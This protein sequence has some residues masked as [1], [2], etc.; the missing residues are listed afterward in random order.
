MTWATCVLAANPGPMTL[1]GT[2][3]WVLR[4]PGGRRSV[5]VDPGPLD[6]QHLA[7][8]LAV[9]DPVAL[10]LITHRHADHTDAV[11]RFAELTGAPVRAADPDH[12]I[13]DDGLSDGD[14]VEVDGLRVETLATPGHTADSVSFLLPDAGAVLTGDTVLGRGTSVVAQ[15]DGALGPY[16]D[17]LRRLL[18]LVDGGAV[19]TLWPGH[20]PVVEDP[21]AV[22]TGYLAHRE[23]RLAQVRAAVA[24]GAVTARD[25]VER[26]Y[27]DVDPVLWGAAEQS[28]AAQLA[29]LRSTDMPSAYD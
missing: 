29:Y 26:V 21:A 17:S 1:D 6:E 14:Q 23:E 24:A 8:V 12:R 18:A 19:T 13:G 16:L 20:G 11:P 15:P 10:V 4:A 28:V 7:A 2:N 9:A 5:V 25:V 27:A 22:L 3:T